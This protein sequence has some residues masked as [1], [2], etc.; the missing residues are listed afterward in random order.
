MKKYSRLLTVIIVLFVLTHT[1]LSAW[2]DKDTTFGLL[3]G[4][5]DLSVTDHHPLGIA[6]QTDGKLLVT[7]WRLA[8]NGRKRFFLRRYLS[9]GGVDTSF[10]NNGSAISNALIITTAHYYG[11]KI[12][13]QDNGPSCRAMTR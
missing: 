12:V 4:I 7:G 5:A 3:G 10:G 6:V 11:E 1:S 2:G 8:G 9:N 13:V